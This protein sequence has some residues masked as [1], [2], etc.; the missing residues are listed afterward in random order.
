MGRRD[1]G[2]VLSQDN[3]KIAL[4]P[5]EEMNIKTPTMEPLIDVLFHLNKNKHPNHLFGLCLNVREI[6][7]RSR[8]PHVVSR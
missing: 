5:Y 4:D 8:Y 1:I 3:E 7:G 6:V 2:L